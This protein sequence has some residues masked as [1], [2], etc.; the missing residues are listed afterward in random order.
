MSLYSKR[1]ENNNL[2]ILKKTD[3]EN[4][5]LN[6]ILKNEILI[7][8]RKLKM[9]ERKIKQLQESNLSKIQFI[10][11]LSHEIKST[12]NI[13]IGFSSLIASEDISKEKQIKFCQNTI[14][15]SKQLLQTA[16]FTIDEA[17][18]E[19][20]NM[21][22]KYI[23]FCPAESLREIITILEQQALQKNIKITVDCKK[24]LINGDKRRLGQLFYNLI[25]N[26]IKF[27]KVGGSIKICASVS[28]NTFHFKIS[29]T[30]CGIDKNQRNEIFKFF[31]KIQSKNLGCDENTGIG[32]S[33]CQKIVKLHKG[34]INFSSETGKG[35]CFWFNIPVSP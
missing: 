24:F 19:T 12:L 31:S 10:A 26:A 22:I 20:N 14:N 33:V 3:Y 7:K 35:T 5:Y 8:D 1:T 17:R 13:V 32:L 28:G 34:N 27:N 23:E 11:N 18:A 4:Q 16:E 30:G 25:N 29:D 2:K 15:A 9:L 21:E 6:E